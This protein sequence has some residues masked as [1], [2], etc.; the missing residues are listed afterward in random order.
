ME[1]SMLIEYRIIERKCR[2][3]KKLMN[4]CICDEV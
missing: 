2:F 4:D 1:N 3:C